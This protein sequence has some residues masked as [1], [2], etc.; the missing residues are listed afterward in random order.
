VAS[1]NAL[2][3]VVNERASP[4]LFHFKGC[5]DA[6]SPAGD[7]TALFGTGRGATGL[8]RVAGRNFATERKYLADA[9]GDAGSD[10]AE[11]VGPPHRFDSA[12]NRS[13]KSQSSRDRA[14]K[15]FHSVG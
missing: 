9:F 4:V 12:I 6:L 5:G 1:S 13:K 11:S 2:S 14:S 7:R 8:A 3:L 15:K 10:E